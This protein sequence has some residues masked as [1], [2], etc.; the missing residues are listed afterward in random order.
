MTELTLYAV[1]LSQSK[2][3]SQTKFGFINSENTV[4]LQGKSPVDIAAEAIELT[5]EGR[6]GH[7]RW[8]P[9]KCPSLM[10]HLC[11]VV[12]SLLF[13]ESKRKENQSAKFIQ[14]DEDGELS[15]MLDISKIEEKSPGPEEQVEFHDTLDRIT[16]ALSGDQE[17]EKFYDLW[18]NG[19]RPKEI[20]EHLGLRDNNDVS[21][22]HRKLI[23]RLTQA[24]IVVDIFHH[25]GG[26]NNGSRS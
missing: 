18:A 4:L 11:G 15:D 6:E 16:E 8:D 14:L 21:N 19:T 22:L 24:G 2:T 17:L 10:G 20:I 23:R 5:I 26:E 1:K 3:W 13:N 12:K 7:R 25:M 9:I